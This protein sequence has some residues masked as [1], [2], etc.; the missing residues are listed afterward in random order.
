MSRTERIRE[1]VKGSQSKDYFAEKEQAGWRLVAVE[2]E[3]EGVETKREMGKLEVEIPY[4]LRVSADSRRL[5]ED[6]TEKEILLTMMDCIVQ[7][8]S[9]AHI[10]AELNRKNYRTRQGASWG[11]IAVFDM[12]PRLIEV[13]PQIFP[14]GEWAE[15]RRHLM[16]LASGSGEG[17]GV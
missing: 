7:D 16:R 6:P 3:R 1:F 5:E 13:G 14:S 10:A 9:I 12:L 4:G 15:R 17:A 8:L 11:V 2:W